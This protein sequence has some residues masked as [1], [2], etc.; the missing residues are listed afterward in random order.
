MNFNW[1]IL[2]WIVVVIFVYIFG[3]FEG[4]GQGYKRRKAEE[5]EEK[6]DEFSLFF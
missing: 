5:A 6:N 1:S 4:R 2:I 3:L